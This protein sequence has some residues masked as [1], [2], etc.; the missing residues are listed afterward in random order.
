MQAAAAEFLLF[1]AVVFKLLWLRWWLKFEEWW[2]E[3]GV[4]FG[5]W[6][7]MLLC[8]TGEDDTDELAWLG[9]LEP[10]WV[11]VVEVLDEEAEEDVGFHAELSI[12]SLNSYRMQMEP[13]SP[14]RYDTSKGSIHMVSSDGKVW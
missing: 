14:M 7:S 4:D 10:L 12:F 1:I 5:S 13:F 8:L 9:T 6:L 11:V 2:G 3:V